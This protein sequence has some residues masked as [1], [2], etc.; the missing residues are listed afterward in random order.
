MNVALVGTELKENL[1]LRYI[2]SSLE[3]IGHGVKMVSFNSPP[4]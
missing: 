1:G 4:V 3:A 2:A